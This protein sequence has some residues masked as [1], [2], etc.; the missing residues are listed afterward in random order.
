L[1][2]APLALARR[3]RYAALRG[4]ARGYVDVVRSIPPITWLFLIFYGLPNAGITFAPLASGIIGLSLISAA[5]MAEIYRAGLGAVSGGQWEA[6]RA[7][8]LREPDILAR[9]IGPQAARVIGP[10]AATYAIGLLKDSAVASTIG[11]GE[12][13]FHAGA[14]TQQEGHGLSIF[15]AAAILYILLSLP[16]AVMSRHVDRRMRARFSIA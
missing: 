5:Y 8:G 16:L 9:V 11:V 1:A 2:G 14:A 12:I 6:G 4:I 3:S 15:L 7:I 10:P 13:T